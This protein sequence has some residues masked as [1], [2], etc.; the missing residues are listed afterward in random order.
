MLNY[1]PLYTH[2]WRN[3]E[4]RQLNDKQKLL[5]IYIFSNPDVTL[6][7]IYSFDEQMAQINLS[8]ADFD[9]EF[10]ELLIKCK[11]TLLYDNKEGVIWIVNRF[12]K[13]PNK[14]SDKV[15]KGVMRELGLF[16][17]RFKEDF[18]Q[19]YYEFIK[20]HLHLIQRGYKNKEDDSTFDWTAPEKINQLTKIYSQP[21]DLKRFLE[22]RNVPATKIEDVLKKILYGV[23]QGS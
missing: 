1:A 7:G 23:K 8:I 2:I 14:T 4:F 21:D 11:D 17:H 18:I 13:M 10:K 19:K 3:K 9:K 5:F 6:S 12:K 15:L 22:N 20:N 16:E